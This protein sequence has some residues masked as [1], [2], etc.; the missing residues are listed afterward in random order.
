MFLEVIF[1]WQVGNSVNAI[2]TVTKISFIVLMKQ[3]IDPY[4][5]VPGDCYMDLH[6][7][8]VVH[9]KIKLCCLCQLL[10]TT[11]VIS[12]HALEGFQFNIM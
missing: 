10:T 7:F 4:Y 12:P 8:K 1:V 5:L 3:G 9:F 2:L 6:F 11:G